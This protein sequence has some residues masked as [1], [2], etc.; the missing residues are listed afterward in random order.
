M[1]QTKIAIIGPGS[2]G[3]LFATRIWQQFQNVAI[4]DY[5]KERAERLASK[6]LTLIEQGET[7]IRAFPMVSTEPRHIGEQDF[8]LVLVKAFQT[9]AIVDSLRSLCGPKTLVI[10]LQ[11]GIGAGDIIA[12][13]VSDGNLAL[14]VT[15]HGANKND[16]GTA[17]H[18][19]SGLTILGKY[20]PGPLRDDRLLQ[21]ARILETAGFQS[22]VV[23]DIYPF[24]WKKL[25]VN[26]GINPITAITGLKNGQILNYS[27]LL[28]I[29]EQA[30]RE[31][32]EVMLRLG[33]DIGMDFQQLLDFVRQVC[34]DTGDN[35]SSMLQD[36]LRGGPTEIDFINGAV[37]RLARKAGLSVPVNETLCHLVE[38][39]SEVSG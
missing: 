16:E 5:K 12:K 14:G 10:S 22:E 38:F 28:A 30:V 9:E 37:V 7:E 36:R 23:Q 35:I 4:L 17:I 25:L 24:L 33:K 1:K 11:N 18:A 20:Q 19:G 6:G 3:I 29:Q 21:F 32:F 15:M 26:V 2:L 8:V 27:H 39:Y 34:K 13:E 31:G